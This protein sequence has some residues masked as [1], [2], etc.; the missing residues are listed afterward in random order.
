[1][2]IYEFGCDECGTDFDKLVRSASAVN[3]VV[4]PD[5]GSANVT[6]KFS[7]FASKV[8]GSSSSR[9]STSSSASNCAPG[10]G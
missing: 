4:C 7:T 10:G 2:P 5:C 1:M 6:K 3:E 8:A 9:A